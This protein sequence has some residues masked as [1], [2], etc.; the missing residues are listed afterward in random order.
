MKA[1]ALAL[2][3]AVAMPAAAQ[4]QAPAQSASAAGQKA[5]DPNRIICERE[6]VLG[7]RLASKKVCLTA[8]QWQERRREHR[9]TLEQFQRMNT[10]SG[11]PAG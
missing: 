8:Q 6:E 9:E 7:S 2:T 11:K 3:A 10:S 1:L 4:G 5:K